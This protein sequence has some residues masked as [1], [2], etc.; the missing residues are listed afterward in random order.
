MRPV[1]TP[2]HAR[3]R[4][5]P[6]LNPALG[7]AG[8]PCGDWRFGR[9]GEAGNGLPLTV[10]VGATTQA[11]KHASSA[12]M[13][14]VLGWAQLRANRHRNSWTLHILDRPV[15]KVVSAL[16]T[17]EARLG[18]AQRRVRAGGSRCSQGDVVLWEARAAWWRAGRASARGTTWH[19][20][21]PPRGS[22][23]VRARRRGQRA[24]PSRRA[25]RR[26]FASCAQCSMISRKARSSSKVGWARVRS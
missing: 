4:A 7:A 3:P 11:L 20:W 12:P 9:R 15:Q 5:Q 24:G 17:R 1:L 21:Q 14:S 13:S 19:R 23:C 6:G 16:R 18:N 10:A 2:Q 26:P 8:P 25:P 22:P